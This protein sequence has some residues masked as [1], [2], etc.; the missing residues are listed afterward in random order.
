MVSAS[1]TKGL[2]ALI[3]A[4][5][6]TSTSQLRG[7]TLAIARFGDSSD[8][9][10]RLIV[11]KMG[12]DPENDVQLLQVGNSPERYAALVAGGIHA[13]IADP[14]DVVRAQRD[15]YNVLADQ[16]TLSIDY[17][18]GSTAMRSQLLREQPAVARRYLMAMVEG[19]HLYKTRED[20]GVRVASKQLQSDDVEAI[21]HAIRVFSRTI[22]PNK[23]FVTD[24]GMR[25]I[26]EEVAFS[27]PA[28]RDAPLDRFIDHEPLREIDRSGFIDQLY[29]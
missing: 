12:M 14:M 28:A 21:R 5:D 15:G 13:T 25:P 9:M 10:T 24:V 16:E 19:I 8:T 11:R 26:M 22:M 2:Y 27:N 29:R 4:K 20:E 6:I 1:F 18:G 3:A 17:V 7:K 23:P